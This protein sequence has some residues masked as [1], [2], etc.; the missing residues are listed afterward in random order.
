M[1]KIAKCRVER[2]HDKVFGF[3]HVAAQPRR[4]GKKPPTMLFH[5]PPGG[6]LKIRLYVA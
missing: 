6:I 1:L 2:Q 3:S 5:Q 4:L